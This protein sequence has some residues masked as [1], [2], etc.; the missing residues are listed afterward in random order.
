MP[1]DRREDEHHDEMAGSH[2]DGKDWEPGAGGHATAAVSQT[3]D[4]VVN[5]RTISFRTKM[6]PPPMNPI[7][8]TI[9]AAMREGSRT[10]RPFSSMSVKPYLE[11][12]MINADE[13]PTNV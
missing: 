10:T 11:T 8:V 6:T 7:P 13:T 9:W 2:G 5:P 12:S 1:L 3:I 4:A